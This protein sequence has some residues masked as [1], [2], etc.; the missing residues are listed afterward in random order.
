MEMVDGIGPE[1]TTLGTIHW[2][3][4]RTYN[5]S[6]GDFSLGSGTF[7]DDFHV[8]SIEW[9]NAFIRWF[10]D[11]Q[12]FHIEA[13][14]ALNKSELREKFFFLMNVAVGGN[15]PESPDNS[16]TFPQQMVVDY[17]RVYEKL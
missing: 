2:D 14:S 9:D 15:L 11:G 10:V 5:F 7:A 8:F 16:T 12:Q 3:N 4:G 6:G 17:I 1:N 13:V